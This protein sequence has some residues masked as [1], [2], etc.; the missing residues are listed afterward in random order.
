[1]NKQTPAF[2]PV[3]VLTTFSEIEK[4]YYFWDKSGGVV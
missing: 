3:L 4:I 1:M 2:F